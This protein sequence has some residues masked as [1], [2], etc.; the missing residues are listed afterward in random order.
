[1]R[2]CRPLLDGATATLAAPDA[3]R[4]VAAS[5]TVARRQG[6]TWDQAAPRV[7]TA[8]QLALGRGRGQHGRPPTRP[9]WTAT[10]AYQIGRQYHPDQSTP[11]WS[12]GD[13]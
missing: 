11:E 5:L 12:A 1:M 7:S 10:A 6:I 4:A 9:A 2:P 3:T 8:A 13:L